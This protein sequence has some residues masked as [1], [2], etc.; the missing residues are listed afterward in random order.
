MLMQRVVSTKV[1]DE[2]LAKF[3]ALAEKADKTNSALLREVMIHYISQDAPEE[4]SVKKRTQLLL[5]DSQEQIDLLGTI[6]ALLISVKL[7]LRKDPSKPVD[8]NDLVNRCFA[9]VPA[10]REILGGLR[11]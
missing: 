10:L 8:V 7:D 9:N 5:D 2:V 1:S 4:F 11:M 6:L 3:S